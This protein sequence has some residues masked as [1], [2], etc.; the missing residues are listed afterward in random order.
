[1][2]FRCSGPGQDIA[3]NEFLIDLTFIEGIVLKWQG[4]L[5]STTWGFP[6]GF[7]ETHGVLESGLKHS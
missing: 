2:L 1:M 3:E 6:G 4:T 7:G 5:I